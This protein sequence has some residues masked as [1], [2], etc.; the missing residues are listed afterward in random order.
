MADS[1]RVRLLGW[2][3]AIVTLVVAI[4]GVAV[5]WMTW[6]S[7]MAAID[8]E[9]RASAEIVSSAVRPGVGGR[10]DVELPSEATTYF[11]GIRTR[12]YYAVWSA[13]GSLVDRSDPDIAPM[14]AP[15]AAG[16]TRGHR[17][18]VVVRSR[19]LTILTGRDIGDVWR[20]LWSL[21]ITMTIVAFVGGTAALGGAWLLAGRALA[22]V[23]RINETARRMAEGDLTARIEVDRAETELDQVAFALNLAFDRQRESVERQRR[24]TADASH[25][26]RTPVATIMA[27]L[28][29]ALLRDRDAAAYRDSLETCRRAGAR[30]QS[31]VEG[32]LTLARADS[33]ELALRRR[34]VRLDRIVAEAIDMLRPLAQQ[35]EVSFQ[36]S[37]LP[38]LVTGDPDRLHDL[39]TNL[40]FNAVAYTQPD[41][42]VRVEV[43]ADEETVTL[44]VRDTGIGIEAEDLPRIF[45]RFYRSDQARAR[46]PAGAGLGLALAKW[47]AEA[48]RGSIVCSSEPGRCSEFVVR[49]PAASHAAATDGAGRLSVRLATP[50]AAPAASTTSVAA[51]LQIDPS[52]S[53]A[54]SE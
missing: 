46:E 3:A 5:C 7:R 27:E 34:D 14:K 30:M 42:L 10:F 24:F 22:P 43:R 23:Q 37:I 17:R 49:L 33:G 47:I 1:L 51:G 29:W 18:E 35:R 4:V 32:L 6:Q 31:L 20:E 8:A 16:R 12:P 9:L 26:L 48:H 44:V 50:P 39:A 53:T 54:S 2:Y 21:A 41:G 19:D 38:A 40:L 28:D 36:I 45:D 15:D 11:Q 13:D 52:P 25:E